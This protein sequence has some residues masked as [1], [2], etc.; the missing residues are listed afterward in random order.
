MYIYNVYM[1]KCIY[2]IEKHDNDIYYYSNFYFI[3]F[4]TPPVLFFVCND[5]IRKFLIFL[6]TSKYSNIESNPFVNF[7]Y[8]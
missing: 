6:K 7:S 8:S 1:Y 5:F 4:P 2:I 3:Y